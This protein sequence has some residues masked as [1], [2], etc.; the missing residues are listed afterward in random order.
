MLQ[1]MEKEKKKHRVKSFWNFKK[2]STK[3]S[4]AITV[5]IIISSLI[6]S[7]ININHTAGLLEK[8]ALE[9]L[10]L[11]AESKS[12]E[13]DVL[14][15]SAESS[16]KSLNSLMNATFDFDKFKS[17][18]NYVATYDDVLSEVILESMKNNDVL[19]MYVVFNPEVLGFTHDVVYSV[20]NESF[21]RN[22]S[23]KIEDFNPNSD[24]TSWF[25]AAKEA[26]KPLWLKPYP[27]PAYN[28][29]L[30]SYEIPI[31][32]DNKLIAVLGTSFDFKIFIN[33]INNIKVYEEGYAFLLDDNY[34]VLVH[35][36]FSIDQN[37][38]TVLNGD[39]K[40]L[41]D[42][43]SKK[44]SDII[45]YEYNGDEKILSFTR[46]ANGN[47][48]ALTVLKDEIFKEMNSN[49]IYMILISL[50]IILI[51]IGVSLFLGG[52]IS[53]P[54][55]RVTELIT[56]TEKLDLVYASEYESLIEY[57]DEIGT[58]SRALIN[59]RK[60]LRTVVG[61]IK[62]SSNTIDNE[63]ANLTA[64]SEEMSSLSENVSSVIEE[65]AK[66]SQAQAEDLANINQLIYEFGEGLDNIVNAIDNVDSN[67]KDVLILANESNNNMQTFTM[68]VTKVSDTFNNLLSKI[69]ALD[70]NISKINEITNLINSI[71][72]QT[73]LLA[74]NAAI[75]AARAGEAGRGF[76]VVA[77]EIRKLAEQSK[78]SSE[79]INVLIDKITN[80][81]N[82]MVNTTNEVNVELNTQKIDINVVIDS[83]KKIIKALD[84]IV[85]KIEV[86]NSSA[87]NLNNN[88]NNILQKVQNA[89]SIAEE[90]SASNEE[91]SAST[92]EVRASTEEVT[93]IAQKLSNMT[94]EMTKEVSNFKI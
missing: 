20:D 41:T 44:E 77:E 94:D 15:E 57:N 4:L 90:I 61:T 28:T 30:I 67:A 10:G 65:G 18:P 88:K 7:L 43:M 42:K 27:W 26:K 64:S 1:S 24:K 38:S 19:S 55:I 46:V 23:F 3:I 59:T 48:I 93:L 14:L 5:L 16:L 53:K 37:L 62:E 71:A 22:P 54:I 39:L 11:L 8:N 87:I 17:D 74:L 81:T 29:D 47:I 80:D 31:Y 66:G 63:A 58:M 92:E 49:K 13:F 50:V 82:I 70:L 36:N 25:Y 45:D 85:P 32:E 76:S 79:S 2:I 33:E 40:H 34:D 75:E 91:I 83:F 78:E 6:L 21:I 69:S 84:E 51:S 73:N 86:I 89:S 9:Q 12:N 72:E 56:K 35:P 52:S 60:V 68:S